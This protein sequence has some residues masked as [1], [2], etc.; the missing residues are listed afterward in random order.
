MNP[1]V[2]LSALTEAWQEVKIQKTRVIL[3][4][5]GVVAAVAA[6]STVMA[7]S[8]LILQSEKEMAEAMSGR[9]LTIRIDISKN[10]SDGS[11]DSGEDF[12]NPYY[13]PSVEGEE[14]GE[15]EEKEEKSSTAADLTNAPLSEEMVKNY[16]QVGWSP[17]DVRPSAFTRAT[18][19]LTKRYGLTKY[20]RVTTS[21]AS[22]KELTK[23]VNS[24]HYRGYP[25]TLPPSLEYMGEGMADTDPSAT[26][27]AVK[28]V[29]PT[30]KTLYRLRLLEGRW[31]ESGD[32]NQRIVPVILDSNTWSMLGNAPIEEP[33][34]LSLSGTETKVRVVGVVK[35]S[36]QWEQPAIYTLYDSW[37]LAQTTAQDA[38][39]DFSE[40]YLLVWVN[41]EQ[42]D[43]ARK[44]LPSTLNAL[45]GDKYKASL[46]QDMMGSY[47]NEASDFLGTFKTVTMIIGAIVILLG[48]L[49][50][51][52]VAIVTVRQR[53]R[54]IGI[55]RA[56]GAS[57][58]RI[59]FSVFLES[60]VATFVAGVIGLML[61]VL[62]VRNLPLESMDIY[63][64]ETPSFPMGT[65]VIALLISTGIGAVSGII[66]AITAVRVK[67]ID[68][69]RY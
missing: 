57:A 50:L 33:I 10:S 20:S 29:D 26:S 5:V 11:G 37:E 24:S 56:V 59:F 68:A 12:L 13:D 39:Y 66:P 41:P 6:M 8:D 42:G 15:G 3:S 65:A 49:G 18:E 51:L 64:Q 7:L 52:N 25:V 55:R 45:L 67:P 47:V 53:I 54:E 44:I 9:D 38:D 22:F 31:L 46:S 21:Y 14:E 43:E 36:S 23:A 58:K 30:Y 48:A 16:E 35:A 34:I 63:L 27:V 1:A 19:V 17:D 2:I 60:V 4:L 62:I 28:A 61:S 32:V 40:D 69:I